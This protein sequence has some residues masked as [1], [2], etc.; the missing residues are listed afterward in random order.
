MTLTQKWGDEY[1]K[2][3]FLAK[4][5]DHETGH[6]WGGSSSWKF[7]KGT[8][9]P[10][11]ILRLNTSN[12]TFDIENAPSLPVFCFLDPPYVDQV[13]AYSIDHANR[14]IFWESETPTEGNAK[15]L[16]HSHLQ[17]VPMDE[18]DLPVDE[19]SYW[20][21]CDEFAG[22]RKFL[23]IFGSPFWLNRPA[24]PECS[25]TG[26]V[27][28]IAGIGYEQYGSQGQFSSEPFFC[29]EL[30]LQ[31]FFCSQCRRMTIVPDL[32]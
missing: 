13:Q 2:A 12:A 14:E 21:I 8:I 29:G 23:R 26:K 18:Q 5:A 15:L 1:A 16:P 10:T 9:A 28:F 19:S 3:G 25:C 20:R 31:C 32:T 11:L 4:P 30:A 27:Q 24:L 6:A 22:G 17:L 7:A